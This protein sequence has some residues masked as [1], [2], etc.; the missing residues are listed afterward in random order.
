MTSFLLDN[1]F[2]LWYNVCVEWE[3]NPPAREAMA[4]NS[5]NNKI[6]I[7]ID[8]ET[9]EPVVA[10]PTRKHHSVLFQLAMLCFGAAQDSGRP[11]DDELFEDVVERVRGISKAVLGDR[12]WDGRLVNGVEKA[13]AITRAGKNN[14]FS[15]HSRVGGERFALRV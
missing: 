13:R 5:K 11:I 3:F 15:Y 14:L 6:I 8:R 12:C 7:E 2:I 4:L 1:H 9:L 10:V